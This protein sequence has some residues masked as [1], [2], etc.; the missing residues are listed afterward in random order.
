M[1]HEHSGDAHAHSG[2]AGVHS[3]DGG[4]PHWHDEFGEHLYEDLSPEEFAA[5]FDAAPVLRDGRHV[6]PVE[7]YIYA[8]GR[9]Y[10]AR[11]VPAEFLCLSESIDLHRVD[12]A[13]VG[14]P[15]TVVAV[16]EDRLVPLEDMRALAARLPDARLHELSSPHG[17][18][19]F[20]KEPGQLR[21]A[22]DCLYGDC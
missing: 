3:H 14:V 16:R 17:H 2:F 15:T 8:R 6:F 11:V 7:D 20:L 13:Q 12:A 1:T 18:D 22:F 21:P 5:R 9:D 4:A 19:A 10:A